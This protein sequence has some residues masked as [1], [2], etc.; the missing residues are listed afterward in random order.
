MNLTGRASG[1]FRKH[2][3]KLYRD[4]E[5]QHDVYNKFN[6]K[7]QPESIRYILILD[8]FLTV[9]INF[10]VVPE[11]CEFTEKHKGF[12]AVVKDTCY[13]NNQEL[14]KDIGAARK[15][16]IDEACKIYNQENKK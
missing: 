7:Y 1:Q 6:F 9:G 16:C 5:W 8:W 2:L 13:F 12:L 3:T 14:F 15:K 10:G 4:T 11:I